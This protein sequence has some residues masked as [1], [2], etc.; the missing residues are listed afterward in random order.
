MRGLTH[1]NSQDIEP[2]RTCLSMFLV[3]KQ[4]AQSAFNYNLHR[5]ASPHHDE[6][7]SLESRKTFPICAVGLLAR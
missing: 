3:L 6:T 1:R 2:N 4:S 7:G 5:A